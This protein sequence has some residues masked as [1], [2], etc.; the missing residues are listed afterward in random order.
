MINN[1]LCPHLEVT[2]DSMSFI[3]CAMIG[4]TVPIPQSAF[5]YLTFLLFLKQVNEM[6]QSRGKVLGSIKKK[7]LQQIAHKWFFFH[8]SYL[9]ELDTERQSKSMPRLL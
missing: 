5:F 9:P 3:S 6:L 4:L 7:P 8:T 2:E 1:N